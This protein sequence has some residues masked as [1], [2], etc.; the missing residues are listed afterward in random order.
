MSPTGQMYRFNGI[1]EY[2]LSKCDGRHAMS[3]IVD[4]IVHD[5]KDASP[6]EVTNDVQEFIGFLLNRELVQQVDSDADSLS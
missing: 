5:F 3:E 2:I 6:G 1:G 4:T